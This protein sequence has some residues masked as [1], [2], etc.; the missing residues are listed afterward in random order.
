MIVIDPGRT[1]H[2]P[3]DDDHR[4]ECYLCLGTGTLCEGCD[5][6][7]DD[8]DRCSCEVDVQQMDDPPLVSSCCHCEG[9]GETPKND[10]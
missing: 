10:T 3:P 5:E 9:T 1:H 6:P 2:D 8:D 7:L 4:G